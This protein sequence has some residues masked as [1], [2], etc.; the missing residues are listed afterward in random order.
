M[1]LRSWERGDTPTHIQEQVQGLK[2]INGCE[3]IGQRSTVLLSFV[4][5]SPT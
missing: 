4:T 3:T 5:H 1:H 2:D